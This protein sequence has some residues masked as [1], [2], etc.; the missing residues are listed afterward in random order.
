[1]RLVLPGDIAGSPAET[2]ALFSRIADEVETACKDGKLR[3]A[4]RESGGIVPLL[5]SEE[6]WQLVPDYF[7]RYLTEYIA[8]MSH[9]GLSPLW[10]GVPGIAKAE[11]S[12]V[13]LFE[14]ITRQKMAGRN[15]EVTEFSRPASPERLLRQDYRRY[16]VASIYTATMPWL[17][18]AGSVI[19]LVRFLFWRKRTS[20][21]EWIT[22]GA[23]GIHV[24]G[25]AVA[26]SYLSA[27]EGYLNT[28][29][30]SACYP[31]AAIF[32]VLATVQLPYVLFRRAP[33]S[34]SG[35]T[36]LSNR[37]PA[38]AI[39]SIAALLVG[40][41]FV[42]SGARPG[43]ESPSDLSIGGA[44]LHVEQGKEVFGWEG[45]TIEILPERQGW[46][47]T[48]AASADK[49]LVVFTGWG[50]D[51]AAKQPARA[52]LLFANGQFVKSTMPSVAEPSV[53]QGFPPNAHGG[54]ALD[55]P[56]A[57]ITGKR[58]R[59]FALLDG[60]RAGELNY[61]RSYPYRE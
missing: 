60:N 53:E 19:F 29:F 58:V 32:V 37:T 38:S 50:I 35:R 22:L 10:S 9:S 51:L 13:A 46:I 24:L 2:Q 30:I 44:G 40:L 7:V 34:T 41:A 56:L 54:F 18:A 33:E 8:P 36:V 39:A 14:K 59:V 48:T 21:W 15:G 1:M 49:T 25:R 61:P 27:V 55:V 11:P 16:Q 17:M 20:S 23:L 42:Y 52:I 43:T 26:F 3:C 12:Q 45:Q 57:E 31:M 5:C 4:N 47:N 6:Q 28:R